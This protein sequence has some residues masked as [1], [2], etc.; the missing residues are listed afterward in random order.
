MLFSDLKLLFLYFIY[1]AS[2]NQK[3]HR[4][5]WILT[6]LLCVQLTLKTHTYT[7]ECLYIYNPLPF[8]LEKKLEKKNLN[9]LIN[10]KWGYVH[11]IDQ[12]HR[13]NHP[14]I[15]VSKVLEV[16]RSFY[17]GRTKTVV[18]GALL[19]SVGGHIK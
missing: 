11:I 12:E 15:L 13:S 5:R 8:S 19:K 2:S 9:G 10:T 4:F 14:K 1:E 6:P 18:N 17:N 16:P 7:V 3:T